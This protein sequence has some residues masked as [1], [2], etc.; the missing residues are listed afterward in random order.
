M[1]NVIARDAIEIRNEIRKTEAALDEALLQ[2]SRLIQRV[3]QGRQNPDLPADT[4]QAAIA[5]IS[6][7]QQQV[8]EG[9]SELFRAHAEHSKVAREL[10][11]GDVPGSTVP[12][13][14]DELEKRYASA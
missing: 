3:I 11:T 1:D 14:M 6:R 4:C 10:M 13:G 2:A 9:S 12:T 8:I 5:R 7:A